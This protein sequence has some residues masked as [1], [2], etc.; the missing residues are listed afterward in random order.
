MSRIALIGNL[1]VDRV[2]GGEPRPGGGVYHAAR[3]AVGVGADAV[4]VTR[5]ARPTGAWRSRRSRRSACP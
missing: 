5:C 1:A 2:A 3:A 4:V